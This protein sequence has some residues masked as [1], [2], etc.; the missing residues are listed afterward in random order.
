MEEVVDRVNEQK[1]EM[2]VVNETVVPS[3]FVK[4]AGFKL[5]VAPPPPPPAVTSGKEYMSQGIV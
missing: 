3:H 4:L 5:P 1:T 2:N